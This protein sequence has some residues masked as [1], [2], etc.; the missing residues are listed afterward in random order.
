MYSMK[1]Q[2]HVG[3]MT[4]MAAF[5]VL[6]LA[7][8]GECRKDGYNYISIQEFKARMDA[9]DHENGSMAV[10]TSQTEKEYAT[11][12][13]DA[14]YPTYARPLKTDEDLAKL[15]PFLEKSKILMQMSSSS[16]RGERA[17][18]KYPMTISKNMA[19]RKAGF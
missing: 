7:G 5:L 4:V 9:G 18:R 15:N 17:G 2:R 6:F 14:A 1:I 19:L 8:N 13:I 16:V 11:G 12:C 10:M 3:L